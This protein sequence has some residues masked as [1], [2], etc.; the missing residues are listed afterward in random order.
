MLSNIDVDFIKLEVKRGYFFEFIT[1]NGL[2]NPI[3]FLF[4]ITLII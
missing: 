1:K 3:I 2:F 4:V